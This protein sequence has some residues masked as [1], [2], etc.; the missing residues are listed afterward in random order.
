M[1]QGVYDEASL[2]CAAFAGPVEDELD[3]LL[4]MFP[5]VRS[6]VEPFCGQARF[7]ESFRRRGLAYFG[8]DRNPAMLALAPRGTG[9]TL[10]RSNVTDF[11][12]GRR[13]DLAWCPIN[14]LCHLDREPDIA[15]HLACVRRH[16][17]R[18]SAYVIEIGLVS[19]TGRPSRRSSSAR[20]AISRRG[21]APS[22]HATGR[23]GVRPC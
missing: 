16:L 12:L 6:V 14:S 9:I 7:A 8:V 4:A 23:C 3:W 11:D 22:G 19:P 15:S 18:G 1:S 5:S 20:T 10:V 17:D 2:Y 21:R 13:V